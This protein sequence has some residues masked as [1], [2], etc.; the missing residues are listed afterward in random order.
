VLVQCRRGGE[1][2]REKSAKVFL[3]A[4]ELAADKNLPV[5]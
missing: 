4:G 5:S 3:V 1:R 2:E